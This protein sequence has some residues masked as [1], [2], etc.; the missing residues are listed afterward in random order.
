MTSPGAA[1]EPTDPAPSVPEDAAPADAAPAPGAPAAGGALAAASTV[2]EQSPEDTD[3]AW[4]EYRQ[5]DDDRL[6]RD[7]PPHW[8]DF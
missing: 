3:A 2:P 6:Y 8:D 1:P 4:G 7:R 5:R